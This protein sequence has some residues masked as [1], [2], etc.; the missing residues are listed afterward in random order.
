MKN[1][2]ETKGLY[3]DNLE[4]IYTGAPTTHVFYEAKRLCGEGNT[5][6]C[7]TSSLWPITTS[8]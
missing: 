3:V 6:R 1:T 8:A 4:I 5:G 2:A 7:G